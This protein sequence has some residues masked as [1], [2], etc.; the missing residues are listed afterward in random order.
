[1]TARL[2]G[3]SSLGAH[4]AKVTRSCRRGRD[5]GR[6]G[7][8]RAPA[9]RRRA[10]RADAPR[11][12]LHRGP[13][14]EGRLAD[15]R[16]PGRHA[17]VPRRRL[18]PLLG[19]PGRRR[20]LPDEGLRGARAGR[21]DRRGADGGRRVTWRPR[22]ARPR[23][24]RARPRTTCCRGSATCSTASCSSRPSRSPSSRSRRPPRPRGHGAALLG[25]LQ[26][27]VGYD[28][29][30]VLLGAERLAYVA[31]GKPTARAHYDDF[32]AVRRRASPPGEA[33][34]TPPR[35]R[36]GSRTPAARSS[37]TR[38]SSTGG[39]G[40]R[41]SCR[42]RCAATAARSSACSRCPARSRSVR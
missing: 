9:R 6:A 29:A 19:R 32:L 37:R 14:A 34:S 26:R 30:A 33:P 20:P 25:V 38:T 16:H 35:C 42:C 10:R 40:W 23:P 15:R 31:V 13:A 21:H 17:D 2:C 7:G 24:A 8:V 4:R 12:R 18:R 39:G 22:A 3:G 1:M 41:R 36:C 27:F 5:R 11:L 28:L